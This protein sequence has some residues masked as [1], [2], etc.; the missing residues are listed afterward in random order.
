MGSALR[1]A[2]GAFSHFT[3]GSD[4][5]PFAMG[6]VVARNIGISTSVASDADVLPSEVLPSDIGEGGTRS[7]RVASDASSPAHGP[8]IPS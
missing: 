5:K 8:S 6:F 1:Q 2:S 3:C 7:Q 4:T